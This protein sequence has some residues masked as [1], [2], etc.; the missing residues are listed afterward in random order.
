M[1]TV[2]IVHLPSFGFILTI[3]TGYKGNSGEL[4]SGHAKN[5]IRIQSLTCAITICEEV[6]TTPREIVNRR[7]SAADPAAR[8]RRY[9]TATAN[10]QL[11]KNASKRKK[12]TLEPPLNLFS[13]C[14]KAPEIVQP[15]SLPWLTFISGFY[16]VSGF[17][18]A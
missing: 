5:F 17:Y 12:H 14:Q 1:K 16:G 3:F 2:G 18:R 13:L 7:N 6:P 8:C 4:V 10:I 15:V 11:H 9:L